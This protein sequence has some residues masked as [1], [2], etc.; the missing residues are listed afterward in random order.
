ML[1]R[2]TGEGAWVDVSQFNTTVAALGPYLLDEQLSGNVVERNGNRTP[3]FAPQGVYPCRGEDRWVAVSVTDDVAWAGLA[4][5]VDPTGGLG[6]D[7]AL[8]R[9]EGRGA[10]HDRLDEAIGRWSADRSADQAAAELQ[11]AGVAAYPVNDSEAMLLDAQLREYG[12]YQVLPSF[13]FPD[14]DLFSSCALRLSDTPGHW[15]WAAPTMAEHTT[16]RLATAG[17][18]SEAEID[19]LL[20]EGAAFLPTEPDLKLRRPYTHVLGPLGLKGTA[21]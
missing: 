14:G 13:R 12:W 15:D 10:A 2:S 17:G 9:V 8:A 1:F 11:A 19:G 18:L 20:G 6:G 5:L 3:W 16:E 7:P 21:R 4:A